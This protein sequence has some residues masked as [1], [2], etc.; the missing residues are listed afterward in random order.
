MAAARRDTTASLFAEPAHPAG[1][2]L[3]AEG[4]GTV[5]EPAPIPVEVWESELARSLGRPVRVRYGRSRTQPVVARDP[6]PRELRATP[7]LRGGRVVRL[8]TLFALAPTRVRAALG[9]WLCVGRRA[10]RASCELDEW[11]EAALAALPASGER[12]TRLR[13][14][15]AHHDLAPLT[16]ALV[17]DCFPDAFG[18]ELPTPGVTWG[19]RARSTSRG[20]L[21]LGSFQPR[22]RLI[23][24]HPVLDQEAVPRW[25]VGAVLHHELLHAIL[26]SE[27]RGAGR[28]H[29]TAEF[30]RR[31]RAYVDHARAL[32]WEAAHVGALV[33]SART[34]R[35]LGHRVLARTRRERARRR[36]E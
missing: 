15:G 4:P 32:T 17:A 20:R 21:V 25:F 31:E 27:R 3:V 10:R 8:H 35:P 5:S 22:T 26:P 12:P 33:R 23:R 18:R 19:R 28:R 30:R 2:A 29:H 9:R 34:G 24:I 11:L 13:P 1:P 7:T 6:T 36:E 14:R 16:S